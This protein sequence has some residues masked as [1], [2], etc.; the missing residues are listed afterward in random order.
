METM[1]NVF[2]ANAYVTSGTAFAF[3]VLSLSYPILE[4]AKGFRREAA[5]DCAVEEPRAEATARGNE[6]GSGRAT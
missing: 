1:I 2:H 5:R 3:I 4:K 6:T